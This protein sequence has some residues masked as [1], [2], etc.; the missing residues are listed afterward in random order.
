M[1][2]TSEIARLEFD[3]KVKTAVEEPGRTAQEID[4]DPWQ[5][6]VS[7]GFPQSDGHI[8]PGTKDARGAMMVAQLGPDEFLVTGAEASVVFHLRGKQP[9][10][11]SQFVTVKQGRFL[12]GAWKP[13][14]LWN[15][16]ETDRGLC[17]HDRPEVVRVRMGR[18]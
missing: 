17:F 5:A 14:R 8:A 10:M 12:Q 3:G 9:W 7:F 13:I 18:F 16:D 11:R 15:G 2:G 4:F 1:L 6:T